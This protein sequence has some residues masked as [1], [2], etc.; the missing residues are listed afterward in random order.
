MENQDN[1]EKKVFTKEEKENYISQWQLSGKSKMKFAA[2]NGLR[3][4]TFVNWC[5]TLL[6]KIK[7]ESPSFTEVKLPVQKTIFAEVQKGSL[8]IKFYQPL[9][10][11]YFQLLVR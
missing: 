11:E 7:K 3:Y 5:D 2:E 9:P 10:L 8:L 1:L 4:Y 6:P